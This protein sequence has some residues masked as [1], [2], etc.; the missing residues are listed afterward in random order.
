MGARGLQTVLRLLGIGWYVAL[1]I[2]GFGIRGVLA[3][4]LAGYGPRSHARGAGHRGHGGPRR[5]VPHAHGRCLAGRSKG[6]RNR[7]VSRLLSNPKVLTSVVVLGILFLVGIAG[8]AL[9]NQFGGGF[10]GTPLAH[11]QLPAESVTPDPSVHPSRHRRLPHYEHNGRHL[12]GHT[13]PGNRILPGDA[14]SP[15]SAR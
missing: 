4:R 5:D 7:V 13:L 15:G 2:V 3:R 9:G 10:L 6:R 11:I 8:G 14:S 12:G 1:S